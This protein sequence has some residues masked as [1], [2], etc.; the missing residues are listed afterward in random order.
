M[1]KTFAAA[2]LVF[3][4][5]LAPLAAVAQTDMSGGSMPDKTMSDKTMTPQ[6]PMTK[7]H[8][9]HKKTLAKS[10]SHSDMSKSGDMQ[11]KM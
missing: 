2:C 1:V 5:A 10:M 4:L 9:M 8:S 11:P 6:K 3:G 7:H